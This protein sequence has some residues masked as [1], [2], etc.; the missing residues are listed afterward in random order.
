MK[1]NEIMTSSPCVGRSSDSAGD[2]ARKMRDYDCGAVPI[3][4][5]GRLV[6]IVTDRDLAIRAL[7][8]GLGTDAK[9]GDIMTVSPQCAKPDDDIRDIQKLMAD[10]QVR[11]IPIVDADGCCLGIVSQ[12]DIAIAS[13]T[14]SVSDREVAIVVEAISEPP[15]FQGRSALDNRL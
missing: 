6:G 5:N 7:A 3:V 13:K 11:R 2:L 1:A 4:D 8:E 15:G 10:H 9:A 12:A 14:S